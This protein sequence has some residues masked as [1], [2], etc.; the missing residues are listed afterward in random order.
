MYIKRS[1]T[2]VFWTYY[3]RSIYFTSNVNEIPLEL[4]I[5]K[6]KFHCCKVGMEKSV[7]CVAISDLWKIIKQAIGLVLSISP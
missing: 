1:E 5:C 2:Y 3:V 6:F 4:N 7:V